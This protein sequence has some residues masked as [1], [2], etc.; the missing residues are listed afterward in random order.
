MLPCAPTFYKRIYGGTG[1]WSPEFHPYPPRAT[2]SPRLE[3]C[4]VANTSCQNNHLVPG[5]LQRASHQ[6]PLLSGPGPHT[7]QPPSVPAPALPQPPASVEFCTFN[8]VSRTRTEWKPWWLK[9]LSPRAGPAPEGHCSHLLWKSHALPQTSSTAN[10]HPS[11]FCPEPGW[12][13]LSSYLWQGSVGQ[14]GTAVLGGR[15]ASR[16]LPST[17]LPLADPTLP[18]LRQGVGVGVVP[19]SLVPM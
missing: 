19:H 11:A 10:S 2:R 18:G 9:A 1:K 14:D 15:P 8:G 3:H 6:A 13:Q 7:N 16:A 12:A 4:P 5:G 17:L